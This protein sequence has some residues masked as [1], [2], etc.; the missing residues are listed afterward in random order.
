MLDESAYW[1][2]ISRLPGIGAKRSQLLRTHFGT[3]AAAWNAKA[4]ELKNALG[5]DD[6]RLAGV[7][8]KRQLLDP[9]ALLRRVQKAGAWVV[10]GADDDYPEQLLE[11]FDPPAVLYGWGTRLSLTHPRLAVVGSRRMTT[12]GKQVIEQFMSELAES[13]A[14][15]VSGLARGVDG[16]A[17]RSAI[18]NGLV[19][20]AILGSG[21]AHLYPPEH[22]NLALEIM[23]KGG[24][25]LSEYWP[26]EEPLAYHFPARN[27]I[28][29]ALAQTILVVEAD[30]K[31][32]SLITVDHALDLGRD[33]FAVPGNISSR[34]S[35]GTNQLLKQGAGLAVD[36]S[37]ILFTWGLNESSRSTVL[38]H[39]TPLERHVHQ[40]LEDQAKKFDQLVVEADLPASEILAA[41]TALEL[42]GLAIGDS[43][44]NYRRV[45]TY[46]PVASR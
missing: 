44:Q 5:F 20:W 32:G 16:Q 25:V 28:I 42:K 17:H 8:A 10:S 27:R 31:S 6:D 12:Y 14:V 22:K 11:L 36:A 24:T 19:T 15:I 21:F 33:V 37:D 41:I 18:Q 38:P 34:F 9:E 35:R 7:L 45:G 46:E 26:D 2:A 13:Q 4:R 23:D 1:L 40:L 29:A 39:L 30:E 43:N 3:G